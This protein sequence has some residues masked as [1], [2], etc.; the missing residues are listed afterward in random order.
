MRRFNPLAEGL[1][2]SARHLRP[3]GHAA[4]ALALDLLGLIPALLAGAGVFLIVAGLFNYAAP[5]VAQ[6]TGSGV[7]PTTGSG[8]VPTF[9]IAPPTMASPGSSSSVTGGAPTRIV[10]PA[11]AIDLPIIASPPNE[12]FPLCDV[13]EFYTLPNEE[14][15]APGLPQATYLAAHA[16][17]GMFGPLLDASKNRNGQ[18]MI[19][20]HDIVEIYTDDNQNHVYE[21]TQVIRHVPV[22][23]AAFDRANNATTDQLWLQTSEGPSSSS[24]KLQIVASP[25]GVL[26][27]DPADA[28]PAG[29][30]HVCPDAPKCASAGQVGCTR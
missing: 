23:A 4:R 11:L 1:R 30:G 22:S 9:S 19:D 10:I 20:R 21:I 24:L 26:P 3:V 25:V 18:A 5:A 2:S 8:V 7:V 29:K 28:H 13:A 14:R 15:V 17:T 12:G 6:T 16:R 27:A